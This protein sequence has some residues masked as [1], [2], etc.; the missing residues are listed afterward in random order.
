[1]TEVND[2]NGK[3]TMNPNSLKNLELGA[4]TRYQGKVK[5][6]L[7]LLPDT[8]SWLK[9]KGNASRLVDEMVKAARAG[10]FKPIESDRPKFGQLDALKS[11]NDELYREIEKLRS[12]VKYA[13]IKVMEFRE[14]MSPVAQAIRIKKSGYQRNSAGKLIKEILA[15]EG[16]L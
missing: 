15:I 7:T 12:E 9:G 11:E 13:S 5:A 14:L 2:S 6:T 4:K 1:M 16:Q 10:Q 8:L 3:R